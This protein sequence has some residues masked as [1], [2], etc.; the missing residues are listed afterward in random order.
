[1]EIGR[2][3]FGNETA[4]FVRKVY[5]QGLVKC[6][7]RIKPEQVNPLTVEMVDDLQGKS[8][9]H[10]KYDHLIDL[11]W[12]QYNSSDYD[13][14]LTEEEKEM[15]LFTRD[16]ERTVNQRGLEKFL[17]DTAEKLDQSQKA[18][19]EQ[20]AQGYKIS[21]ILAIFALAIIVAPFIYAF[22]RLNSDQKVK[23]KVKKS[24]KTQ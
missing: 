10:Q 2:R 1:M 5:L 7:L 14:S 6:I 23:K 11:D 9:H 3:L 21:Y 4:R 17:N 16:M 13:L 20:I 24:K 18:F 12:T 8:N 19:A 22:Y 15:D